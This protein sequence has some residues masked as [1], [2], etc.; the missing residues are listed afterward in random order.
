MSEETTT[1]TY[2]D[3]RFGFDVL[4]VD[5]PMTKVRGEWVPDINAN[6]LRTAVL[7]GLT[8]KP[9]PLT[10][11]EIRF[12]RHWMEKT[13]TDF[14]ECLGVSHAAVLKWEKKDQQPTGM[15]RATEFRLRVLI[16]ERLPRPIQE[17]ILASQQKVTRQQPELD[18][19]LQLLDRL[20]NEASSEVPHD[21]PLEIPPELI[22]QQ[23]L[24]TLRRQQS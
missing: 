18:D 16:L 20:W 13:S 2:R 5:V 1:N 12:V 22:A 3:R 14:G 8:A 24:K 11:A 10:G 21:E 23:S 4:L 7:A 19:V 15:N 9:G 17:Q 6:H